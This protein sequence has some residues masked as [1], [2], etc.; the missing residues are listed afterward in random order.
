MIGAFYHETR[1]FD[2]LLARLIASESISRREVAVLK[3]GGLCPNC[4]CAVLV[5]KDS[6]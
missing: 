3:H 5:E 4:P 6:V 2:L 1:L